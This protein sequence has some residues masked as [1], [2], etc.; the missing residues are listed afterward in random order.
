MTV[1]KKKE[2]QP[3]ESTVSPEDR[4]VARR[5]Q[6]QARLNAYKLNPEEFILGKIL[7]NLTRFMFLQEL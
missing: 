3:T 2:T 4:A 7:M 1:R 5:K 6:I